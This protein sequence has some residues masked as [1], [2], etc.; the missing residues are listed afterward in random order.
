MIQHTLHDADK[1]AARGVH[2]EVHMVTVDTSRGLANLNAFE[3]NTP[4]VPTFLS[5]PQND[6]EK[7]V[8]V[9]WTGQKFWDRGGVFSCFSIVSTIFVIFHK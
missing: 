2:Q 4:S 6:L 3:R 1:L 7:Q 5:G 9:L 8:L